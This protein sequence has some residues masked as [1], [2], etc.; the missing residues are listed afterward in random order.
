MNEKNLNMKGKEMDFIIFLGYEM[1]AAF[2]P[3]LIAFAILRSIQQTK[4]ISFS[5]V[6]CGMIIAFFIYVVGV[7]HFTGAGTIY[8][9]FLYQL[10][11]KQDQ[12]NLVPFSQNIDVIAYLLNIV[13]FI[14]LGLL[15]PMIWQKMNKLINII[16]IG[17]FFTLLIELS[18]LFNNRR[19]DVDDI[20]LNILGAVIGFGFFKLWDKFTKSKFQ[21]NHSITVELPIYILVIFFGRFFIFNEMGFAKLLYG[22]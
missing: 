21:I 6:H 22:F 12:I 17:F 10:E 9:G 14:P 16:E 5:R 13:L 4:G 1:F 11:L 7:Y 15:V 18:Q 19:T 3:F 2:V 8:D 20:L